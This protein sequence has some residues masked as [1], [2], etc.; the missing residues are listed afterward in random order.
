MK[1]VT[2]QKLITRNRRIGQFTVYASLI[3]LIGGFI[4]S[5]QPNP[6]MLSLAFGAMILGLILSQV[7]TYYSNRFVRSPRPDEAIVEN[8]KTLEDKYTLYIYSTPVPF[9]LVS[10]QGIWV[11][12]TSMVDGKVVYEKN[13][14][15]H[16][17]GNWFLKLFSEG[18][19]RPDIEIASQLD[20]IKKK[21]TKELP[22]ITL[23]EIQAA[24]VI[25]N[26]KTEI[27]NVADA[28]Y[29]TIP[30]KKIKET[31]RRI[32]KRLGSPL[33]LLRR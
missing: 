14:W 8:L 17:G 29:P 20:D 27:E 24:L 15:R 21:F 31:I 10:P 5:L 1:I 16:K 28:P 3:V 7:G 4:A 11:L 30:C 2:N 19:G 26:P 25:L 18:L 22:D 23:P 33:Q 13:R 6:D 9:L 32:S 12:T